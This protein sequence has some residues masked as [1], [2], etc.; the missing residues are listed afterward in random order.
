MLF[1]FKVA[2]L[3]ILQLSPISM[4]NLVRKE[5]QGNRFPSAAETFRFFR[6]GF[7]CFLLVALFF[8]AGAFLT[9]EVALQF[10][11]T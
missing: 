2:S 3:Y 9:A 7:G 10:L 5:G 4:N 8:F 1:A 11:L 6:V